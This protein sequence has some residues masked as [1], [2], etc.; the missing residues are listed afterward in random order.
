MGA[1]ACVWKLESKALKVTIESSEPLEH[2]LRVIGALYDV[3]LTAAAIG[4]GSKDTPTKSVRSAS[5][6]GRPRRRVSAASSPA[7]PV[8]RAKAVSTAAVRSWAVENGYAVSG[9]GPIAASVAAAYR[10]ARKADSSN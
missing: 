1:T 6:G 5:R 3:T 7:K 9:R 4:T 10:Q 8:G 2:V